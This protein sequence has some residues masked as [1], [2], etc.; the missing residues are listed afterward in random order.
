MDSFKQGVLQYLQDSQV[1]LPPRWEPIKAAS[2]AD[3][4]VTKYNS[5]Q[6]NPTYLIEV[7]DHRFVLRAKPAGKLL[8][9]AHQIER[10]FK[11]LQALHPTGFPVPAPISYNTKASYTGPKDKKIVFL[12]I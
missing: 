12:I 3:V 10:E 7:L 2:L 8:P 9:G 11:C 6:S 1:K 5:G 4:K